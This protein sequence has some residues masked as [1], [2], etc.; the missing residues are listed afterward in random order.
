MKRHFTLSELI[1]RSATRLQD[2]EK[3]MAT[4]I[5]ESFLLK[6]SSILVHLA[7]QY[8]FRFRIARIKRKLSRK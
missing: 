1:Q 6:E 4:G 5:R 2:A 3:I 8:W 7:I